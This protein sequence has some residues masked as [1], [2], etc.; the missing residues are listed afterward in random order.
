MSA[1]AMAWAMKQR[2][3]GAP[4]KLVLLALARL[5]DK[6]GEV[7]CSNSAIGEICEIEAE[8]VRRNLRKLEA[9]GLIVRSP[10][11]REDGGRDA[12]RI[13]LAWPKP[14]QRRAENVAACDISGRGAPIG[15]E[16][17]RA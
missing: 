13:V 5:A 11:F 15:G 6:R 10:I 9:S 12:N 17:G 4:E 8:G 3:G 14:R 7:H 16:W 2:A 1:R